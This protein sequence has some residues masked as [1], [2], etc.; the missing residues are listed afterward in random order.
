MNP[1]RKTKSKFDA[2]KPLSDVYKAI[3]TDLARDNVENHI[4]A[5]D[6]QDL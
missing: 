3:E 2:D 1:K 5:V 6:L 4:P